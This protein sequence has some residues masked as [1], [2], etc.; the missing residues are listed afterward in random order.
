MEN[1]SEWKRD[2]LGDPCS[3]SSDGGLCHSESNKHEDRSKDVKLILGVELI[4]LY[5]N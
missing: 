1:V 4:R 2:I 3:T 5:M